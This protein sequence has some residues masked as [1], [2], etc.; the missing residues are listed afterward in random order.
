MKIRGTLVNMLMDIDPLTYQDY[1]LHE[2]KHKIIYVEMKKALYGML[3]S[4]LL[5]YKKFRKDFEGIGFVVNP[6][7]PCIV[8]RIV[9][10]KQHTITWHVDDLKSSHVSPKVNNEFLSWLKRTY[11]NN[12]IGKIKATRGKRH[13]YLAITLDYESPGVLKVNMT[14]YV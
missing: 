2:K 13:D 14:A 4:S 9:E 12:N 11:A 3:Q 6:Y 1:V 10:G 7:N 5:Y 8:N